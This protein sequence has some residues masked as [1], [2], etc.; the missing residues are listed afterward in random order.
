MTPFCVAAE[1]IALAGYLVAAVLYPQ[2]LLRPE[3]RSTGYARWGLVVGASMQLLGLVIHFFRRG[4]EAVF[5]D[6]ANVVFVFVLLVVVFLL[7]LEQRTER[8]AVG[9]FMAP[10]LFL[11]VFLS[12][13]KIHPTLPPAK[14]PWFIVHISLTL[15]AYACFGIAFCMSMAYLVADGLLKRKQLERLPLL[16]P[17]HVA[18][19]AAHVAAAI[20]FPVYTLGLGVAGANLA[21]QHLH[22]D[23]KI[24]LALLTWALYAGYLF[25]HNVPRWRGRRVNVLPIIGFALVI[26][27]FLA[28]RHPER[29]LDVLKQGL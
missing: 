9:A 23:P 21:A 5:S 19:R 8:P 25:V 6:Y 11:V 1:V 12:L 10:V 28:Y 15:V 22:V 14:Q 24:G 18:D 17:L 29:T 2:R 4:G 26:L 3:S 27:N 13:F 20:G 16:P 7:V